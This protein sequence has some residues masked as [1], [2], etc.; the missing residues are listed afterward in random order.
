MSSDEEVRLKLA[1]P[2]RVEGASERSLIRLR[3]CSVSADSLT[4]ALEGPS[5]DSK[6]RVPPNEACF[7][8][9]DPRYIENS[10]C[11]QSSATLASSTKLPS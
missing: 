3:F 11:H 5:I 9:N 1:K 4:R 7:V 2:S 6:C 10:S 8:I